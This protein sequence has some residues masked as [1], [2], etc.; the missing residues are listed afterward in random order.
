MSATEARPAGTGA[1][2]Q[3]RPGPPGY[4]GRGVPGFRV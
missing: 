4:G 1:D 3:E 2:Q